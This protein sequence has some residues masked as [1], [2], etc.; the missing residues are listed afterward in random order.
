[1]EHAFFSRPQ[2]DCSGRRRQSYGVVVRMGK[3]A[4]NKVQLFILSPQRLFRIKGEAGH[5]FP[6]QEGGQKRVRQLT[7]GAWG[8][9][10][11]PAAP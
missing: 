4:Q 3:R 1:M 2:M 6:I 9:G 10:R 8:R 7:H 11:T 5:R